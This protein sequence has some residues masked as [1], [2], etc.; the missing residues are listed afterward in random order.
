MH[1]WIAWLLCALPQGSGIP[2]VHVDVIELNYCFNKDVEQPAG[3]SYR[4]WIFWRW[5][6]GHISSDGRP[7]NPLHAEGW[8]M[9]RPWEHVQ[10]IPGGHRLIC[11][12]GDRLIDVRARAYRRTFTWVQD[13]PELMDR[14]IYP[15][16][17]RRL[18]PPPPA[19]LNP[20]IRDLPDLGLRGAAPQPSLAVGAAAAGALPIARALAFKTAVAPQASPGLLQRHRAAS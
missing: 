5:K 15:A 12:Y 11:S 8:K 7:G 9:T 6:P 16:R 14:R 4:Q 2:V 20:E 1:A 10:R 3:A 19:A 18:V 17:R 13:D